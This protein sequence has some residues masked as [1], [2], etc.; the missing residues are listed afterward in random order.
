MLP[1]CSL[2][3]GKEGLIV[4]RRK[5]DTRINRL[6]GPPD[7]VRRMRVD[8]DLSDLVAEAGPAPPDSG[9]LESSRDLQR[10]MRVRETPMDSLPVELIDALL[11]RRP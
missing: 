9:W 6:Q 4:F 5:I 10:G 8:I 2:G 7:P 3:I 11:S 1:S